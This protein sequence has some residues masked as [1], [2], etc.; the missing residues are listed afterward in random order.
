MNN[1]AID[2]TAD[3]QA[4][5]LATIVVKNKEA[6]DKLC[7]LGYQGDLFRVELKIKELSEQ[8]GRLTTEN[9]TER[10]EALASA[11]TA[12]VYFK[13]TG[14]D[15]LTSD[16]MLIGYELV[17]RK[18]EMA[19]L[20]SQEALGATRRN[21]LAQAVINRFQTEKQVDAIMTDDPS[22]LTNKEL[23]ILLKWKMGSETL[24]TWC[25]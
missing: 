18:E 16:D 21:E 3:P 1:G 25:G 8:P 9:T 7:N 19:K 12:G 22:T 4:A 23:Y 14:G 11:R 17:K 13:V 6:C 15:H 5:Q 2:L 10:R 20:E 24:A